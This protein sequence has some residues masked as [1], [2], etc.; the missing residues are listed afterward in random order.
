M[1][2][3][4]IPGK[5]EADNL[6][7]VFYNATGKV[8]YKNK[9][10]GQNSEAVILTASKFFIR[11]RLYIGYSLFSFFD[12]N[13]TKIDYGIVGPTIRNSTIGFAAAKDVVDDMTIGLSN[14]IKKLGEK[15]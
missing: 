2:S 1:E 15:S 11:Y 6:L 5:I 14:L 7:E 13:D 10:T 12:G 9:H 8:D 4:I 3:V